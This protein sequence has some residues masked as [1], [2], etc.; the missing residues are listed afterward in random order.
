MRKRLGITEATMLQLTLE[1]SELRIRP[2]KAVET[3]AGSPWLKE[4]YDLFAPV[5]EQAASSSEEEVNAAIDQAVTATRRS[6]ANR[7]L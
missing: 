4:L 7:R 1:G 5:R 6:Y 3:A 2:V